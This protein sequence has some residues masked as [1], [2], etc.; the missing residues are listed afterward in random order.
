MVKNES[1]LIYFSISV[2]RVF[3]SML[4]CLHCDKGTVSGKYYRNYGSVLVQKAKDTEAKSVY[5]V[6]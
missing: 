3:G 6:L 5:P 2:F 4:Q 1:V